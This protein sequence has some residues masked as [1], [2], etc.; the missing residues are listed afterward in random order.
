MSSDTK[1]RVTVLENILR[2][3]RK[4]EQL[5]VCDRL[6]VVSAK[7]IVNQAVRETQRQLENEIALLKRAMSSLPREGEMATKV[8]VLEPKPFNGAR[9]AKD[10]ENFMWDME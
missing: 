10:L 3:P 8:K 6:D 7:T 2:V 9:N 4:G 5:S 1:A